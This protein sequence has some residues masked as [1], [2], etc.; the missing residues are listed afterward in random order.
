MFMKRNFIELLLGIFAFMFIL[1]PAYSKSVRFPFES[2]Q[3][4]GIYNAE[5]VSENNIILYKNYLKN[6]PNQNPESII[7]GSNAYFKYFSLKDNVKYRNL[8]F[9]VYYD[10]YL[11][12]INN[13]DESPD[14]ELNQISPEKHEEELKIIKHYNDFGITVGW[15]EPFVY[16]LE[17]DYK[18]LNK[19]FNSY[20]SKEWQEYFKYSIKETQQ[21]VLCDGGII[22]TWDEMRKRIVFLDN[23]INKYPNFLNKKELETKR[24]AY[25]DLYITGS[26]FSLLNNCYDDSDKN[27]KNKYLRTDIKKSYEKFIRFNK[28][29]KYHETIAEYYNLIKKH[30]FEID[31]DYVEKFSNNVYKLNNIDTLDFCIF[32]SSAIDINCKCLR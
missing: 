15:P 23:F 21:G 29:N 32:P 25:L 9:K 11:E 8:A 3:K 18:F 28:K 22:P 7:E 13:L 17:P 5:K 14:C 1:T 27:P 20:L 2:T 16:E 12:T 24:G 30:N 31:Y 10:F 6:L 4:S 19:K 26:H